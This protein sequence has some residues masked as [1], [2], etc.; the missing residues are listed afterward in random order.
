MTSGIWVLVENAGEKPRDISLEVLC[1][2]WRLAEKT[3]RQVTAVAPGSNSQTL[4]ETLALYGANRVLLFDS[5]LLVEYSAEH[6]VEALSKLVE[7]EK[8]EI[9]LS[10]ATLTGSD[11]APRLAARLRTGLITDCVSLALNEEGLLLGTKLTHGGKVSSTLA[12][13]ASKPQMATVKADVTRIDKAKTAKKPEVVT[14]TPPLNEKDRHVTSQGFKK[15]DPEMLGL[16]EAEIIVSG[17]RGVGNQKNFQILSELASQLRGVVAGSRGALDE[18]W[19]PRNKLVGQ[20]GSSVAPRLYIACG[21]SGSTYHVLG[22]KDSEAII[23]INKDRDAP[24]FK[25]ADICV[26][27]DLIEVIPAITGELRGLVEGGTK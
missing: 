12:C 3:K 20:S 17:G 23:A 19:I 6:Y 10:G 22:M 5:P 16:E 27:G 24:I 2:A 18:G 21:I 7:E 8:P 15:V 25:L 1:T 14:L 11:L 26:V 13:P 9:V 4:A